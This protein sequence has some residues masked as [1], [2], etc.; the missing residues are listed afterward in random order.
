MPP[1]RPLNP[2]ER[3]VKKR[4]NELIHKAQVKRKYHKQIQKDNF[5]QDTPDYV[6]EIFGERTIDDEGNIVEYN[7][8]QKSA[9]SKTDQDDRVFY[10][11]ESSSDE[12]DEEDKGKAKKKKT[13]KTRKPNPFKSEIQ[14]KEQ[15]I[16]SVQEEQ[17][18]R[19]RERD[20]REYEKRKYYKQRERERGRLMSKTKKGQPNMAAQVDHLLSKIQKGL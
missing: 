11:D 12:S 13:E 19:Q 20:D 1:K 5:D 6:K 10:L 14:Q 17:K 3:K 16:K 9:P 18:R 15:R 2:H 7:N 8:G 4:K